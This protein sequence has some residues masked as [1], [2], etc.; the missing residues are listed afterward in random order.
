ML[1]R[2]SALLALSLLW[3][4]QPAAAGPRPVLER[5]FVVAIDPGHGGDNLGCRSADGHA[6]EKDVTLRLAVALEARLSARLPHARVVLT[7]R[8]DETVTLADRVAIANEAEA[9]LFLSLHANA[10]PSRSQTGFETYVLE[11]RATSHDA[12]RT[13]QRENDDA[14]GAGSERDAAGFLAELSLLSNREQAARFALAIQR[15]QAERFSSRVDRGIK[16]APFDVLMGA[17]MPAVLFEAGFLD[18]ADEGALLMEAAGIER[19]ADGLA[20][21][22]VAQYRVVGRL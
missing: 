10:S 17:R 5:D 1:G 18:H 16:Q 9:D 4:P 15:A 11:A 2:R 13:A 22:I 6:H 8:G 7:R 12:A 20:E 3:L 14:A 19:I 21:A